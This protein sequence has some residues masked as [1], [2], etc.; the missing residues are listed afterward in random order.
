M[1]HKSCN[2]QDSLQ[3]CVSQ[4][5]NARWQNVVADK[6]TGE[7]G[8]LCYTI[9]PGGSARV[10]MGAAESAVFPGWSSWGLSEEY[11]MKESI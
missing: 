11:R 1:F 4:R 2:R 8:R 10:T 9:A 3:V 6:T 5:R 7:D